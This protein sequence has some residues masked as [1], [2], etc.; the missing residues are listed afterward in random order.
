MRF[1]WQSLSAGALA[2]YILFLTGCEGEQP[3][4]SA[5]TPPEPLRVIVKPINTTFWDRPWGLAGLDLELAER[6]AHQLG[7]PLELIELDNETIII[8]T[9]AAGQ[10]DL[11]AMS[12]PVLATWN[13]RVDFSEWLLED[14]FV[15]VAQPDTLGP[16]LPQF[17]GT[18]VSVSDLDSALTFAR[19]QQVLIGKLSPATGTD[20]YALMR[21]VVEETRPYALVRQSQLD[22][23]TAAH[24]ELD[25]LPVGDSV[26]LAWPLGSEVDPYVIATLNNLILRAKRS[27]DLDDV[28]VRHL[29]GQPL[30][31][32][33]ARSF[34]RHIQSRLSVHWQHFVDAS[35]ETEQDP[36]LLAAIGYQES[37]WRRRAKSP[38]GV[39]G[40][41][42]LTLPTA[43]E[44][45]V[46]NRL[47]A[48]QSIFGGAKYFKKIRAR[49]DE[50]VPEPDRT[51]LALA[52]YNLGYG[53]LSDVRRLVEARGGNPNDWDTVREALPLKTQR[54]PEFQFGTARGNEAQAYVDNIR[55]YY[56]ALLLKDS[57]GNLAELLA[58]K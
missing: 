58:K 9:L 27:G 42:M 18:A 26:P 23:A 20:P 46:T 31:G 36:L 55:N 4:V 12:L 10:A 38:T 40:V 33:S 43:R 37:H 25:A 39:R 52:A 8:D 45:G 48:R 35:I 6:L 54:Q 28:I 22:L 13:A 2:L 15:L 19:E 51:W 49:F 1:F 34:T 5:P 7:R 57:Q 16:E 17:R 14:Q 30:D 44:M 29:P 21:A 3:S 47:D 53:H 56:N 32:Y 24:L 41:M 50:T 11:A